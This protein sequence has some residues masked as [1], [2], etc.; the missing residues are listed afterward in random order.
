MRDRVCN[1]RFVLAAVGAVL[2]L[3][4][5]GGP[6]PLS[7]KMSMF[8][9]SVGLSDG[10]NLGGLAGADAHCQRLAVAAGSMRTWRAYLNAPASASA[11]IVNAR[12]RIGIGPWFNQQGDEIA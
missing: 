12:E 9:T 7:P 4:S 5:C 8:V 6:K 10:G 2:P 1:W 3:A 11:P